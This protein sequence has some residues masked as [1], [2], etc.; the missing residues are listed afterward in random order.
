MRCFYGEH[1]DG[2]IVMGCLLVKSLGRNVGGRD[3]VEPNIF[4]LLNVQSALFGAIV[5][6]GVD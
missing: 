5:E 4:S 1:K 2:K 3:V 6:N